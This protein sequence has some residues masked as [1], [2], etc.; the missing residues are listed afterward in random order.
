[1]RLANLAAVKA[2]AACIALLSSGPGVRAGFPSERFDRRTTGREGRDDGSGRGALTPFAGPDE[3]TLLVRASSQEGRAAAAR[4]L[5]GRRALFRME[6]LGVVAVNVPAG[7]AETAMAT[8]RGTA[9]VA[10]VE[11]DRPVRALPLVGG[12]GSLRGGAAGGGASQEEEVPYGVAMVRAPEAIAKAAQA[13]LTPAAKTV[14]VVDTGYGLGHPDLPNVALHGVDGTSPYGGAQRWDV[15][16]NG[17]GTHVAGTVGAVGDNAVGVV[18]GESPPEFLRCRSARAL[19]L[20]A[21]RDLVHRLFRGRWPRP[22]ALALALTSASA[23]L[24]VWCWPS[25]RSG[26]SWPRCSC[27]SACPVLAFA[28]LFLWPWPW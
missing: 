23:S 5:G 8:L 22:P 14:C 24:L 17:H 21:R 11:R 13:G 9:G 6:R 12:E 20:S 4:A 2:F 10:G 25:L 18:G 7:E 1:M 3:T 26:P 27:L 15:D 28:C 19:R 16:G